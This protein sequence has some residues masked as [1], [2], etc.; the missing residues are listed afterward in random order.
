MS[1]IEGKVQEKGII[2]CIKTSIKKVYISSAPMIVNIR[3]KF[4]GPPT[5]I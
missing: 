1:Y 5:E 4:E 2:W 3:K